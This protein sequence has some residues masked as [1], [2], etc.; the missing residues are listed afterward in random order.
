MLA[1]A[2]IKYIVELS[3]W[4]SL[5]RENR[6]KK[7]VVKNSQEDSRSKSRTSLP[8]VISFLKIFYADASACQTFSPRDVDNGSAEI[9]SYFWSR[10]LLHALKRTPS[11]Y[12]TSL[13]HSFIE[14][15]YVYEWESNSAKVK[16]AKNHNSSALA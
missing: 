3:R 1:R 8:K 16:L 6:V 15:N 14:D 10:N 5:K 11:M 12:M 2:S 4:F 7:K 13:T 9:N